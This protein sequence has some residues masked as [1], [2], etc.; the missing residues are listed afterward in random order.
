MPKN[1]RRVGDASA[2]AM[3]GRLEAATQRAG[4]IPHNRATRRALEAMDQTT[5]SD[6]DGPESDE[7]AAIMRANAQAM[8]VAPP[9]RRRDTPSGARRTRSRRRD[10]GEQYGLTASLEGP[11]QNVAESTSEQEQSERGEGSEEADDDEQDPVK[12][13]QAKIQRQRQAEARSTSR[14]EPAKPRPAKADNLRDDRE[15]ISRVMKATPGD[16]ERRRKRIMREMEATP[17]PAPAPTEPATAHSWLREHGITEMEDI[18]YIESRFAE[19]EG[20]QFDVKHLQGVGIDEVKQ[21]LADREPK[22]PASAP[23]A[24]RRGKAKAAAKVP[25]ATPLRVPEVLGNTPGARKDP[26]SPKSSGGSPRRSR[27]RSIMRTM[28]ARSQIYHI[29]PAKGFNTKELS[30]LSVRQDLPME[31][32]NLAIELAKFK[33][34]TATMAAA[35]AEL[36]RPPCTRSGLSQTTAIFR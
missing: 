12:R 13:I 21:T 9:A 15:I 32:R 22:R 2:G 14:A 35:I 31:A 28:S 1:K 25:E 10:L 5:S 24:A 3:L 30:K 34:G 26:G 7:T 6:D 23:P 4:S 11:M 18:R 36:V 20:V 27:S 16:A 8:G 17:A 33:H 29:P 19:A